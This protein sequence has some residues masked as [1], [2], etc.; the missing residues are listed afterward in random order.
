MA[1]K[2]INGVTIKVTYNDQQTSSIIRV[3]EADFF[4]AMYDSALYDLIRLTHQG[5]FTGY[6]LKKNVDK[7]A[8]Y[9][10]T[11]KIFFEI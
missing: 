2:E 6:E 7:S 4:S 10:Y 3:P 1:G 5:F 11:L 9:D 8:D